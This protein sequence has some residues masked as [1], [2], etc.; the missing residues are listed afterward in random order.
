MENNVENSILLVKPTDLESKVTL[1]YFFWYVLFT[2]SQNFRIF[3]NSLACA[4]KQVKYVD[5]MLDCC[6]S[7]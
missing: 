3:K 2:S 5:F 4:G 7:G 6:F 1:Q